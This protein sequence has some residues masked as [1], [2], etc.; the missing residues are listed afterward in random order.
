[1][2]AKL[3]SVS[4]LH[5][6]LRTAFNNVRTMCVE[7]MKNFHAG[8]RTRILWVTTVHPDQLDAELGTR[9]FCAHNFHAGIRTRVLPKVKTIHPDQP[10][11]ELAKSC[12]RT[13][14][15]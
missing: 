9:H 15:L 11:A 12:G 7:T 13:T 10:D 6:G 14:I 2:K 3:P 5:F 4:P 8:I 1:M